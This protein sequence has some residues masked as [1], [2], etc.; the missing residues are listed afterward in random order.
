MYHENY[1]FILPYRSLHR[2]IC[3]YCPNL[4]LSKHGQRHFCSNL[5]AGYPNLSSCLSKIEL[6]DCEFSPTIS[7]YLFLSHALSLYCQGPFLFERDFYHFYSNQRFMHPSQYFCLANFW[8]RRH[9]HHHAIST[10]WFTD[11]VIYPF[12]LNTILSFN[13]Q[14]HF[15]LNLTIKHPNQ[16]FYFKY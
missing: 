2:V 1:L 14:H 13:D 11:H 4:F 6:V 15:C 5:K 16:C 8:L 12:C 3:L 10:D 9:G 7:T